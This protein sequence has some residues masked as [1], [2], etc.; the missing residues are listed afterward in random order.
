MPEARLSRTR[1]EC[2]CPE[3]VCL[4]RSG[5]QPGFCREDAIL[6]RPARCT[7]QSPTPGIFCDRELGHPGPHRGYREEQDAVVFWTGPAWAN[8]PDIPPGDY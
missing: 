3:G 4:Y 6:R 8:K 2:R 7:V 1:G 5:N